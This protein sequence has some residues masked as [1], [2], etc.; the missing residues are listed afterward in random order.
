MN[1]SGLGV[2]SEGRFLPRKKP[3]FSAL[4]EIGFFHL[5]WKKL[6]ETKKRFSNALKHTN[7]VYSDKIEV[8]QYLK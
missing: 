8:Y 6:E 4:E 3:D 1:E 7:I 5:K 2:S